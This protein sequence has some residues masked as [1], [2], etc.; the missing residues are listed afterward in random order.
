MKSPE[1]DA[2]GLAELRERLRGGVYAAIAASR[3]ADLDFRDDEGLSEWPGEALHAVGSIRGDSWGTGG[4]PCATI[5]D[6]A[7]R[8]R[9]R[10]PFLA[11]VLFSPHL[12]LNRLLESHGSSGKGPVDSWVGMCWTAEAARHAVTGDLPAG[13]GYAAGDAELLRPLAARLRFLVLSEPSRWRAETASGWWA[14]V[15]DRIPG[16][17]RVLNRAF[18]PASWHV[19]IK[20]AAEARREWQ[21]FLDAYQ[22][23]PLLARARP[24]QLEPEL[25]ALLFRHI[26]PGPTGRPTQPLGLS[27]TALADS[28]SLTAE[29]KAVIADVAERHLLPRFAIPTVA[30]LSLYDDNP[31][32]RRWRVLAGIAVVIAGLAAA[33]CAAG[34]LVRPAAVAAAVCYLLLCAGV[35]LLPADWGA[36]WLLRMPAASAVGIIALVG[37]LPGGWLGTPPQGLAGRGCAGPRV[38]RLPADRGAQSRGGPRRGGAQGAA[39][40]RHRLGSC[41]DGQPDR[42][43][44]RRARLR[45][46]RRAP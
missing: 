13:A 44:G 41:A 31:G 42:P 36:M 27:V 37:F 24:D 45:A 33:G 2:A 46:I 16:G 30:C 10:P 11:V 6:L 43:G 12:V 4:E 15:P 38:V 9:A 22:S 23:H 34:L 29:D 26:H 32:R 40:R 39:R 20:R 5:K 19:L 25:R 35:L 28:S 21:G 17:N 1:P 8:M 18:G 7:A 14:R 3:P